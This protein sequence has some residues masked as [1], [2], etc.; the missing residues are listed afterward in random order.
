M[1]IESSIVEIGR[2]YYEYGKNQDDI[3]RQF[4][5]SRSTVSRLLK[6]ARDDGIVRFQI[7]DPNQVCTQTAAELERK[8]N[9]EKAVV[10][11]EESGSTD[12]IK[13][14]IGAAGAALFARMIRGNQRIGVFWGSTIYE[15]VRNL[16][17]KAVEGIEVVQMV[18]TLGNMLSD[19][20]ADQLARLIATKLNGEWRMLPA[21][22]VV[23][24]NAFVKAFLKEP[25]IRQ[26]LEMGKKSDI[27][28]VG[29][30][31]CDQE[32]LLA[33]AGYLT[34]EEIS[35][36]KSLGAV[37]EVGC[38]FFTANGQPCHSDI[39]DRT[40]S[41]KLNDL[42][43]IPIKIGLAGG[44]NKVEAIYGALI[45]NYINILVTDLTTAK[46]LLNK[47]DPQG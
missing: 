10:I 12:L 19:T 2:L 38:R 36:L 5:I 18:G 30:G 3:A 13:R 47:P 11:E 20:H 42:K 22:A 27:A 23:E 8:F 43:K 14:D 29:V 46:G 9:L 21:P 40:I 16:T 28:L 17:P 4:G 39:D 26:V 35:Q 32:A 34:A 24:S 41:L 6:K 44:L 7:I 45:G 37:G 33:K 1:P 15:L 31:L 25:H